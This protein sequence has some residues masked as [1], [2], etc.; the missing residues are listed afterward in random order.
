MTY[1]HDLYT[2]T[3]ESKLLLINSKTFPQ[4]FVCNDI[5]VKRLADPF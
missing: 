3:T 4:T 2:C 1:A 5:N